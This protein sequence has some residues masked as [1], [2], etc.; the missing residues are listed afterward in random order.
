MKRLLMFFGGR[1]TSIPNVKDEM[2]GVY[3]LLCMRRIQSQ[4]ENT[5]WITAK[6]SI[7]LSHFSIILKASK[8]KKLN[9]GSRY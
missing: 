6:L 1:Y 5:I 3:L 9:I 7:F 8:Q 2:N 4:F